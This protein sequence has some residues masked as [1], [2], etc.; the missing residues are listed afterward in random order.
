MRH[1]VVLPAF[2]E[3]EALPGT[4]AELESLGAEYDIL[5]INDGSKDG[6]G[7]AAA[8]F[9]R[10]TRRAFHWVSLP[11]NCGIGA[12][13]QT[14]YRFA[15]RAGVYDCVVQFDADGQHRAA[16]IPSLVRECAS[17]NWDLVVGSRFLAA[18]DG[19]G[20]RS[21]PVRRL[22][23]RFFSFLIGVLSGFRASD[24]TSGL[25][26]AGSRAWRRFAERYPDD[27]A[28]PESL[29]WCA[30]LGLRIREVPVRMR[31]RQGGVS[32]IRQGTAFYYML[33]VFLAILVE[34]FRVQ[35][36]CP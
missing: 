17:G 20:F 22:G 28:E 12:A 18:E 26:C 3:E 36:R 23:I 9:A 14:G 31:D 19:E 24:P 4:L 15:A 35:E 5:V 2:N 11:W 25:R 8:E 29:F 1:L 16:D 27:F 10:T 13:M 30:R 21:T 34:R 6:T 7:R 33:K 32:S